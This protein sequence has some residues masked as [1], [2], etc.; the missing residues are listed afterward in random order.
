MQNIKFSVRE[1]T[2]KDYEHLCEVFKEGDF[3]HQEALPHIFREPDGPGRTRE[4][5]SAIISNKNAALFVADND[6]EIIGLVYVCIQDTPNI[7][8]SWYLVVMPIFMT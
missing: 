3:I 7:Y 4:F 2:K 6:D 8:P 5:V 1:V